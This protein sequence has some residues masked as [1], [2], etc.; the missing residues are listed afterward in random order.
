M[1]SS[2]LRSEPE[3][4]C[5]MIGS[6]RSAAHAVDVPR[7]D[8]GVVDDHARGLGAGPAGGRAD[9]VHGGCRQ[10]WQ[11]GDVVERPKRPPLTGREETSDSTRSARV[12]VGRPHRR[13]YTRA[14]RLSH[15]IVV[16]RSRTR[17]RAGRAT[18][19]MTPR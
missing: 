7:G 8:G 4:I 18:H 6:S 10:P 13:A 16:R 3:A 1:N 11:G 17:L 5:L 15:E 2:L 19:D 9:V 14:V 12:V